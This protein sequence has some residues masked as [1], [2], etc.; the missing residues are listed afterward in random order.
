MVTCG[1]P[2]CR[3]IK[4]WILPHENTRNEK[5]SRLEINFYWELSIQQIFE[6]FA[7]R[8][9]NISK[10]G[11]EI[12]NFFFFCKRSLPN[13]FTV[14]SIAVLKSSNVWV[15][16]NML[17]LSG[18]LMEKVTWFKIRGLRR[19]LYTTAWFRNGVQSDDSTVKMFRRNSKIHLVWWILAPSCINQ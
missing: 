4:L 9:N 17:C 13:S 14:F 10:S 7:I 19:P 18:V 2:E 1:V 8:V 3:V 15:V 6:I 5:R 11:V 12:H 16:C